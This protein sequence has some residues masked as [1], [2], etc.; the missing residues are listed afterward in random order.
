M[1][2]ENCKIVFLSGTPII[3]YPNEIAIFY[4]ILRGYIKTYKFNLDTSKIKG[5]VVNKN[6]IKNILK[7][8]SIDFIDF[9][10]Q[11][12]NLLT[13]TQNPFNFV[14]RYKTDKYVGVKR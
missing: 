7:S 1:D 5:K 12:N 13:V 9:K 14:N 3:N 8:V 2:A 4:N 6:F 11:Q 10:P